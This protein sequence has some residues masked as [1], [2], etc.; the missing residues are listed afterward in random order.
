MTPESITYELEKVL[1]DTFNSM[2]IGNLPKS[3]SEQVLKV[4]Q[5]FPTKLLVFQSSLDSTLFQECF[6]N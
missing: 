1:S 4:S 5:E 2:E 3:A 6:F